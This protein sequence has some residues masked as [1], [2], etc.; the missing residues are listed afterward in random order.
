MAVA[1][2]QGAD[3]LIRSSYLA[4]GHFDARARGI[5]PVA[6]KWDAGSTPEP[7]PPWLEPYHELRRKV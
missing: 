4:Q 6:F 1:A 7:Q 3:Q 5:E 2:V